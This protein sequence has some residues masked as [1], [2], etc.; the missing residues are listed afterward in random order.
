MDVLTLFHWDNTLAAIHQLEDLLKCSVCNEIATDPQCLGRC[1]HFFCSD[2]LERLENNTCSVCKLPSSP[3]EVQPDRIISG[4]VTSIKDLRKLIVGGHID[5]V[6][7]GVEA[8]SSVLRTP[9]KQIR[10]S[11]FPQNISAK[12]S[13]NWSLSCKADSTSHLTVGREKAERSAQSEGKI[14][15]NINNNKVGK[16]VKA[17]ARVSGGKNKIIG[18]RKSSTHST[19]NNSSIKLDRSFPTLPVT[20]DNKKL[21][22]MFDS[23]ALLKTPSTPLVNKRNTK[24]E[25]S[26]HVACIKG[27]GEKVVQLLSEGANPN[28]KDNA[29]WTPLHEACSHGFHKIADL[30]LQHGAIVDVPGGSNENPLHDAVTQGQVEIIKLLRSWG[31]SDTARNLSGHTPR[32]LASLC[33]GAEE[34]NKAL[35]TPEDT[36]LQ[37]PP[38]MLPLVDKLVLLGS[39]LSSEQTKKLDNL[40]RLLRARLVSHF[41]MEVSHVIA[42]CSS[43]RI[44][45]QRGL[46][47]MMAVVAGKWILSH[48]WMDAC[49]SQ[50]LA[51]N[52]LHYEVLGSCN[53]SVSGVPVKARQ[54]AEKMCPGLF[55]GCHMFLWGN[56]C[57]PYPSKKDVEALIKAG[58]GIVLA[59]EPNPEGISEKEKTVPFYSDAEGLLSHCSHYIIYQEGSCEPQLKYDMAHIKSLPLSW[60]FS[61]VDHFHLVPPFK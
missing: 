18:G 21:L 38:P 56:F 54:N 55:N 47:Y 25:T 1:D 26:L 31:A 15:N 51:V 41:S 50:E 59:R 32:S 4:L 53:N 46:K 28:T 5:S 9:E 11:S 35:D 17:P 57:N 13:E 23:S 22:K 39:G 49:L 16:K 8:P 40:A 14:K 10:P 27:D 3:C 6:E 2:C 19:V 36:S 61:C 60:L 30:L 29:G 52:P 12:S 33:A 37:R 43:E 34:L 20:P 7:C 45:A 24:G 58:G 48:T 44:V 42:A